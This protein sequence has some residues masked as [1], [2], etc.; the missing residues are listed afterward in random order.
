[1]CDKWQHNDPDDALYGSVGDSAC[2]LLFRSGTFAKVCIWLQTDQHSDVA[3]TS[4]AD[5]H[6][7]TC[8]IVI[9]TIRQ[10]AI[11]SLFS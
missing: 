4:Q 11:L 2:W 6:Q 3:P 8:I 7:P 9:S 10:S 5:S 1:M